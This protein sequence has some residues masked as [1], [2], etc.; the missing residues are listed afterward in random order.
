MSWPGPTPGRKTIHHRAHRG[1]RVIIIFEMR[2]SKSKT[3]K[4]QDPKTRKAPQVENFDTMNLALFIKK[5]CDL[6][7]LCG[8]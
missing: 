2:I 8:E 7:A 4:F 6:C 3:N 1:H 5:L